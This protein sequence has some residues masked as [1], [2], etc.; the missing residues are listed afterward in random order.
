MRFEVGERYWLASAPEINSPVRC[1]GFSLDVERMGDS[2]S[3]EAVMA[4]IAVPSWVADQADLS[5]PAIAVS[6]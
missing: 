4:Y 5:I 6:E 3:Q 2:A 1:M